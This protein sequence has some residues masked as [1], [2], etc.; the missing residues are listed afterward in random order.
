MLRRGC[1]FSV[2]TAEKSGSEASADVSEPQ[3][4]NCQESSLLLG[5][6]LDLILVHKGG[7]RKACGFQLTQLLAQL[8]ALR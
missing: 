7:T 3:N 8:F 6:D 4:Y 1:F 2:V 5:E